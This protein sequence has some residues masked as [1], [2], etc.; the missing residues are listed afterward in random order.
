MATGTL[1]DVQDNILL[2]DC[3]LDDALAWLQDF[4]GR[5]WQGGNTIWMPQESAVVFA[6]ANSNFA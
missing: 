1:F 3:T 6:D 5:G 4:H 2:N